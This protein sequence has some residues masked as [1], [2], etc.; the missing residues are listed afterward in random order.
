MK[1][2]SPTNEPFIEQ[3]IRVCQDRGHRAELRRY[4]SDATRHYAFPILGRLGALGEHKLPDALTAALY[5]ENPNH[6]L[7]G[8]SL[9]RAALR[10][11]SGDAF[12]S[13]ERHFRRLLAANGNEL[14]EL[15][16][17]LHRLFIRFGRE[18]IAIDY[19]RLLWDLRR[20]A[21][22][23]DDVKTRWACDFW[24]APAETVTA[25]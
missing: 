3:I 4:W 12:E 13:M 6:Q 19:N 14:D 20:W 7:G 21:K 16:G 17:G 10:L 9:G 5:A 8:N 15:G 24:Q 23:A 1:T 25:Q 11:G 22:N 18:G 2:E